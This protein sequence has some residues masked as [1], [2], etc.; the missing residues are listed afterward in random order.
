MPL[1]WSRNGPKWWNNTENPILHWCKTLTLLLTC[2]YELSLWTDSCCIITG[3]TGV[4]SI[5]LQWNFGD[6]KGAHELLGFNGD[7]W[8]SWH[9][10]LP[11]LPPGDPDWHVSGRHHASYVHQLTD[12]G[13]REVK[14]LDEGRNW[15]R[16]R[17]RD[18]QY[19]MLH[20]LQCG[21]DPLHPPK[22][23]THIHAHT[24]PTPPAHNSCSN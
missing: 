20:G 7:S 15:W 22:M 23:H 5:V 9:D 2:Y 6:L 13:G 10:L 8:C 12:G 24:H 17:A 14:R 11:V 16:K 4:V 3:N 18:L 19:L 1:I 21:T